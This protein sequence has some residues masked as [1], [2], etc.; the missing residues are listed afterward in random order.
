MM[1]IPASLWSV[2]MCI[3][4]SLRKENEATLLDFFIFWFRFTLPLTLPV[5]GNL[6]ILHTG[7]PRRAVCHYMHTGMLS[8]LI[9]PDK[10]SARFKVSPRGVKK[11]RCRLNCGDVSYFSF[12]SVAVVTGFRVFFTIEWLVACRQ[13]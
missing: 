6:H 4:V 2:I 8:S 1:K 10:S 5:V 7:Y 12:R 13:V 9:H 11:Q 3:V